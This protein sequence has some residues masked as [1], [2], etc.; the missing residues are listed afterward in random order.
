MN[1]KTNLLLAAIILG[2]FFAAQELSAASPEQIAALEQSVSP[3][4]PQAEQ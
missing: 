4:C 1:I 2:G 3:V